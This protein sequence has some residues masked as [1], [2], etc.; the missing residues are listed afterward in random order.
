MNEQT[1]WLFAGAFT[2]FFLGK[3]VSNLYKLWHDYQN[4]KT[5]TKIANTLEQIAEQ[6]KEHIDILEKYV[7]LVEKITHNPNPY[8]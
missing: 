4:R 8:R 3:F 6:N 1:L 5:S 2:I 7:S